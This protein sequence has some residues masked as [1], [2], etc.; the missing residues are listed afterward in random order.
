MVLKNFTSAETLFLKIFISWIILAAKFFLGQIA[1]RELRT[2]F[3]FKLKTLTSTSL[4]QKNRCHVSNF[5]SSPT[6]LFAIL[7]LFSDFLSLLLNQPPSLRPFLSKE[8]LEDIFHESFWNDF[9]DKNKN[10]SCEGLTRLFQQASEIDTEIENT[11]TNLRNSDL[12]SSENETETE[13]A[14]NV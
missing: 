6:T 2:I 7:S 8:Q 14:H 5:K 3:C 1:P 12:L 11:N 10:R 13:R 9:E 4:A